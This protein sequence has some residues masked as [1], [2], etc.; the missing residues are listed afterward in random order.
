MMDEN[1]NEKIG[2]LAVDAGISVVKLSF[3]VIKS[4]LKLL[5]G[6]CK[7]GVIGLDNLSK[8]INTDDNDLKKK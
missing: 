2:T 1:K 8:P 5:S 6:L 3:K 4:G 7:L